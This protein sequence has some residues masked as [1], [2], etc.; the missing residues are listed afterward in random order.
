MLLQSSNTVT[1][2]LALVAKLEPLGISNIAWNLLS[3]L[4]VD[5]FDLVLNFGA[6]LTSVILL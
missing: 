1:V 4:I 5:V 3:L 6:L 2:C